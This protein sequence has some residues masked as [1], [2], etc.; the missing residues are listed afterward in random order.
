MSSRLDRIQKASGELRSV[1]AHAST[2][3]GLHSQRTGYLRTRLPVRADDRVPEDKNRSANA[4]A[5]RRV[6]HDFL[7]SLV[8]F[9]CMGR[10]VSVPAV[11]SS[12]AYTPH[13]NARS[14]IR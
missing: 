9:G 2:S 5:N 1:T 11:T 12:T 4:D 3:D 8:F 13:D 14:V 10:L 6:C 7:V